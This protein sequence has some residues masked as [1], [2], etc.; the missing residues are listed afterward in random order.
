ML[1]GVYAGSR[2]ARAHGP[3]GRA[4]LMVALLKQLVEEVTVLGSGSGRGALRGLALP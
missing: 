1:G 2:G 3:G 4:S